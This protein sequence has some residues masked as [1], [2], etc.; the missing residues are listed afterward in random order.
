MELND[1]SRRFAAK[2]F[3]RYPEWE[4][5][6]SS[7][8][9]GEP[10]EQKHFLDV[11]VPSAN[12]RVPQPLHIY[13][14]TDDWFNIE[15]FNKGRF[16]VYRLPG[17]SDEELIRK[18]LDFL[19]PFVT[20]QEVFYR[21]DCGGRYYEDGHGPATVLSSYNPRMDYFRSRTGCR[22]M[23]RSWRGRFDQEREIP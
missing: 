18:Q 20:E 5:Y 21:I 1:Y 11:R 13:L 7:H 12:P 23:I 6:A 17:E 4:P 16:D 14:E 19:E 10:P 8:P 3:A 22:L 2:L 9:E 15:W